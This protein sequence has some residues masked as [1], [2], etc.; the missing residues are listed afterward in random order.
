MLSNT[1]RNLID[2][3]PSIS[4]SS[5]LSI[6]NILMTAEENFANLMGKDEYIL[7][8]LRSKNAKQTWLACKW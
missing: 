3:F 6:L 2:S 7:E 8:D 1:V 4:N 5:Y